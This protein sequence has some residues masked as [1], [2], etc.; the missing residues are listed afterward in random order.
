MCK[1]MVFALS[2]FTLCN[3]SSF[4]QA[5]TGGGKGVESSVKALKVRR[6]DINGGVKEKEQEYTLETN[7]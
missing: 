2:V 7:I 6:P 5:I 3:D 1:V 4:A